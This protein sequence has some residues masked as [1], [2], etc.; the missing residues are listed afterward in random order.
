M[1]QCVVGLGDMVKNV[2]TITF[3]ISVDIDNYH[4]ECQIIISFKFKVGL[5]RMKEINITITIRAQM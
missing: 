5:D 1:F 2:I 4:D 3:F